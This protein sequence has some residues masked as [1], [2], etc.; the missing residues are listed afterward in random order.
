MT[1]NANSYYEF[2]VG[3]PYLAQWLLMVGWWLRLFQIANMT[4]ESKVK[5]KIMQILFMALYANSSHIS[6]LRMFIFHTM[7]IYGVYMTTEFWDDIF[8]I[9]LFVCLIWFFTSHQQSFSYKGTG[10][11]ELNQY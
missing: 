10:L 11:Q 1:L 9:G 8:D 2:D 6:W 4:L 5:L 7:L 3:C